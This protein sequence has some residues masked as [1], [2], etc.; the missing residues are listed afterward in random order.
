MS[1]FITKN[2]LIEWFDLALDGIE[3]VEKQRS[4]L[5]QV[6]TAC[7]TANT[8]SHCRDALVQFL[9]SIVNDQEGGFDAELVKESASLLT[10]IQP[11]ALT[12][13]DSVK[14]PLE[15]AMRSIAK[16]DVI[17]NL[18]VRFPMHGS[19]FTRAAAARL[20]EITDA[21]MWYE[22][23]GNIRERL[24]PKATSDLLED[25]G[26][27]RTAF[28]DYVSKPKYRE[29]L[30]ASMPEVAAD[31]E[32]TMHKVLDRLYKGT[33]AT[34]LAFVREFVSSDESAQ[35]LLT[36]GNQGQAHALGEA[37]GSLPSFAVPETDTL[38][39][40]FG[41]ISKWFACMKSGV[42]ASV[43]RNAEVPVDELRDMQILS[44]DVR[45]LLAD[46]PQ[47]E[48]DVVQE[49]GF[50]SLASRLATGLWKQDEEPMKKLAQVH[51]TSKGLVAAY[52]GQDNTEVPSSIASVLLAAKEACSIEEVLAKNRAGNINL[53]RSQFLLR[54]GK[55]GAAAAHLLEP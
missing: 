31:Y 49:C 21:W 26:A 19:G 10:I 37:C 22:R 28:D 6:V 2:E 30:K 44:E 24:A 43:F 55:L 4:F 33:L 47:E 12:I 35:Y 52:S 50:M 3:W 39:N 15:A 17:S 34:W 20:Q 9:D 32:A 14:E 41:M 42:L 29:L 16:T 46:L 53:Q 51:A 27:A 8:Q 48:A 54:H 18:L 11:P 5:K 25:I 36:E 23:A 38:V 45:E 1:R 13:C 40:K 7:L